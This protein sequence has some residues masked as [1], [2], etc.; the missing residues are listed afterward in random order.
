[1]YVCVLFNLVPPK[2][3]NLPLNK[4]K[5]SL[6][7]KKYGKLLISKARTGGERPISRG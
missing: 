7:G 5:D 2:E 4:H 3:A 6:M 1:M